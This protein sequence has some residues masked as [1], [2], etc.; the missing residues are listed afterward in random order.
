[1]SE[2]L[3]NLTQAAQRLDV[4]RQA[5]WAALKKKRIPAEKINGRWMMTE[6]ALDDYKATKY[7]RVH[8]V[9]NGRPLIDNNAGFFSLSQTA[10]MLGLPPQKVYFSI[11][12]GKLK[13]QRKGSAYIIHMSDIV[14]FKETYLDIQIQ[15]A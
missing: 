10:K 5:V 1:M 8:S 15:S 3:L 7:S 13:Y 11:Y 12:S 4:Q 2:K 9:F 6:K 14:A